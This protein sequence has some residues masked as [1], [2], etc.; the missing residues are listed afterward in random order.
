MSL[1]NKIYGAVETETHITFTGF[2]KDL[3]SEEKQEVDVFIDGEKVDTI[4]AD[5]SIKE[6]EDK[7]EIYEAT[8]SCFTYTVPE[9]YLGVKHK[10]EFKTSDKREI[11]SSQHFTL[12]ETDKKY[13]EFLFEESLNSKENLLNI[14]NNYK[15]G[16]IAFFASKQNLNDNNFINHIKTLA[17][18]FNYL[19]FTTLYF[20]EEEIEPLNNIFQDEIF[21]FE[22]IC[23][24]NIL[25]ITKQFEV[26][27][28]NE[29]N[30]KDE[31]LLNI[32][33]KYANNIYTSFIGTSNSI[34]IKEYDLN[35]KNHIFITDYKYFGFT[36]NELKESNY[37]LTQLIYNKVFKSLQ[38]TSVNPNCNWREFNNF[39]LIDYIIKYPVLKLHLSNL[40]HK[41][42]KYYE[43]N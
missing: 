18:N 33:M 30:N 16:Y 38:I 17:K 9:E 27:L 36:E 32:L 21:K 6:I 20:S 40:N 5:K 8:D 13:N 23:A 1:K 41:Y 35:Y 39:V 14:N 28:Y 12:N 25:D 26:F 7:Y 37:L 19:K 29:N 31:K 10:L 22:F 11:S 3:T 43:E 2:C 15:K 24:K 34:T 4:L 42:I